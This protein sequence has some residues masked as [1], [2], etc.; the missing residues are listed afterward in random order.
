[1]ATVALYLGE[2]NLELYREEERRNGGG[3]GMF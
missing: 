3:A 2:T 1:M